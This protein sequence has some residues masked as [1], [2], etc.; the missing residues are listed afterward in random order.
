LTYQLTASATGYTSYPSFK[1][2]NAGNNKQA[3][4]A[5]E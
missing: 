5:F 4:T 2:S 1:G 3:F